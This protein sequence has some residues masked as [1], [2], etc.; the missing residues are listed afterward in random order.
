[1]AADEFTHVDY[2][3]YVACKIKK[4]VDAFKDPISGS[5]DFLFPNITAAILIEKHL[6]ELP[7]TDRQYVLNYIS[8]LYDNFGKDN[9][10]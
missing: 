2:L 10:W 6:Q 4:E 7:F 3:Q 9:G 1:M 8:K 5:K